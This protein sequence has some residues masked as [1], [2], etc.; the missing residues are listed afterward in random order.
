MQSVTGYFNDNKLGG[1][2]LFLALATSA[3]SSWV[4]GEDATRFGERFLKCGNGW[5]AQTANVGSRSGS[6]HPV[7]ERNQG[8]LFDGHRKK[9]ALWLET[10]DAVLQ[11]N[12][13]LI[14][15]AERLAIHRN[16]LNLRLQRIERQ[17]GQSLSNPQ[18]RLNAQQQE[19]L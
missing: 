19:F 14:K 10:L 6:D 18:F 8:H 3:T 5:E 11:D 7:Y 4:T 12:G 16:T 15:A 2:P 17:S 1:D 13:N 9:P